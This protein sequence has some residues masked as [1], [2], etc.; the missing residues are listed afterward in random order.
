MNCISNEISIKAYTYPRTANH[1]KLHKLSNNYLHF[2][3]KQNDDNDIIM[4]IY[5]KEVMMRKY[6]S[7][8]LHLVYLF[9][10]LCNLHVT[11]IVLSYTIYEYRIAYH[12][13]LIETM[14]DIV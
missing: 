6:D 5:I 8:I 14:H 11:Y 12:M 2:K 4:E 1:F 3:K 10:N 9:A 7:I 13:L